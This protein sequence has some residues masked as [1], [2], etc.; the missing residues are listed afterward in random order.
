MSNGRKL[1][2]FIVGG[3]VVAFLLIWGG[4]LLGLS[5]A[6]S[7]TLGNLLPSG[8]ISDVEDYR[9]QQEILDKLESTYYEPVDEEPLQ[10]G[11]IDG[12]VGSLDDPYTVYMD[13][14]EY[15]RYREISAVI[16]Q[17]CGHVG[18][19][20]RRHGH[21]RL[22]VQGQPGR[23]RRASSPATSSSRSTVC[24][25]RVRALTKWWPR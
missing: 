21:R 13:P 6:F 18:G 16:V 5:P 20:E 2:L 10:E 24:R 8:V 15:A 11:A 22:H 23:G 1:T 17:R 19:D 7:D 4:V 3:V 9:L 14:E 25:P 12:M